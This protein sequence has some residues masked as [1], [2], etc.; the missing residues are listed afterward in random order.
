MP[1]PLLIKWLAPSDS[2]AFG[3]KSLESACVEA[4]RQGKPG[5]LPHALARL[6]DSLERERK[7]V[8]VPGDLGK[9]DRVLKA[10][11]RILWDLAGS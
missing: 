1:L 11:K 6:G 4:A 2:A 10:I 9:S 7:Q 8:S 3:N 5:R